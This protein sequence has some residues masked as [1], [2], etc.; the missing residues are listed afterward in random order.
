[1]LSSSLEVPSALPLKCTPH[2]Q[3]AEN[4]ALWRC[5]GSYQSIE[6]RADLSTLSLCWADTA[7]YLA[8]AGYGALPFAGC[9]QGPLCPGALHCLPAAG[10]CHRL[11]SADSFPPTQH[12]LP[13]A[14]LLAF[15]ELL[16][17]PGGRDF[18][19]QVCIRIPCINVVDNILQS[20]GWKDSV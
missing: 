4:A 1:M 5:N 16:C 10:T 12:P 19:P 7:R 18:Y 9:G 3:L 17:S 15:L 20:C 13:R 2:L 8:C 11:R 6:T 14:A